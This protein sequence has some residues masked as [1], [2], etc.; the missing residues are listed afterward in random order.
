MNTMTFD[1]YKQ[2]QLRKGFDE[3]TER[4]YGPNATADTHTHPFS[5]EA[6]VVKGEM[7][8]A[9]GDDTRHLKEGDTFAM[10]RE[11]PHSERY[12]SDGAVYWAARK[13]GA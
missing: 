5:V 1:E 12:G 4:A 2:T 10:N 9:C 13:Y 3:V 6:L 7:W 8:L 11:V